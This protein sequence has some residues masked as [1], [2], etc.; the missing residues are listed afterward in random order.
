MIVE[1]LVFQ[2]KYGKGDDLVAVLKELQKIAPSGM[3]RNPRLL[4]DRTGPFFTI[5]AES[6]WAS[7]A[8][9][10]KAFG[11]IFA[12]AK[13]RDLLGRSTAFIESG[14]REFYNVEM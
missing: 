2:A 5:V 11:S 1:R 8:E 7:L 10:E 12:D 13:V 4:T 14:R 3:G 6:E 9:W